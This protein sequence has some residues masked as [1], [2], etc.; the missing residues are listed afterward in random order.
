MYKFNKNNIIGQKFGRWVVLTVDSRTDNHH[1]HFVLC[2]CECGNEKVVGV[3]HLVNGTSKSC[4][5]YNNEKRLKGLEPGEAGFNAL[6]KDYQKSAKERGLEFTLLK[7]EF[8]KLVTDNCYYCD[9]GPSKKI[10]TGSEHSSFIHNGIDRR[11]NLLGYIKDNCVT[12]CEK[13]NVMKYTYSEEDFIGHCREIIQH[14]QASL[15]P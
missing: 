12:C 14:L 1:R 2:R 9:S 4:G 11:N 5:C 7:E 3:H 10:K 8:K 6:F 13:C 15:N